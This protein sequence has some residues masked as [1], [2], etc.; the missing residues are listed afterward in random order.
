MFRR[1]AVHLDQGADCS[2]R[3]DFCLRLA[4]AHDAHLTGIYASYVAPGYFYDEAGLWVR[5]MDRAVQIHEKART[6]VQKAFSE[7]AEHAG[8]AAAWRQG[9]WGTPAECVSRHARSSDVVVVGQNNL[10]DLEA[11]TGNDFVE[12]VILTSGRPVIVLPIAGTF[13]TIGGRVLY[14]WDRGREAARAIADAAPLLRNAAALQV[15]SL[16][17]GFPLQQPSDVPFEDLVAYCICHGFPQPVHQ[18]RDVRHADIGDAILTAAADFSA[19]LIVMGG[20]GHSRMRQLVMGGATR[21]L[22]SAMTVPVLL[23]H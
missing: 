6:A 21:S 12:Q 2:R 8:V 13:S 1:I 17:E 15:L 3:L 18:M 11:A 5:G 23:S 10:K 16:D 20:Y 7:A 14:C 4:K 22:L 19:D 9:E